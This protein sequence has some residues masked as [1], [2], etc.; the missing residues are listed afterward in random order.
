MKILYIITGLGIGGAEIV[1]ANLAS[2]MKKQGHSV[3]I[4]F[5]SGEQAVKVT[6]EITVINL[7]M[8]KSV[9]GFF[10]AMH[11]AK[12]FCNVFQPD[13]VHANLFHAI[14]FS[15]ILRLFTKISCLICTE[16]SNN[17]HGKVRLL[18]EHYTDFLSDM[19]TNVSKVATEYFIKSGVFSPKKSI[20]MYN[21]VDTS[22][23]C[24]K[25]NL[26]LRKSLGLVDNDFVFLN[27]SRF[28]E[29][30]DHETLINAFNIVHR[31]EKNTKLICVGDGELLPRIKKLVIELKL[32]E[33]V[34]FT[35]SKYNTEDYY[36]AS[37][38]F[39]LSSAYEGFGL[40]LVEAMA[41]GLE[42]I[43]T[44]CGGVREIIWNENNFVPVKQIDLL[45][46]K[47]LEVTKFSVEKRQF[48]GKTNRD[49]IKKFSL[50]TISEK[51]E[52]LYKKILGQK[53]SFL[54]SKM[55]DITSAIE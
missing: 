22:R 31:R 16:H 50:E 19:N 54:K 35:G 30:K 25:R 10:K 39:V 2:H 27:V 53:S 43:S 11:S 29:A 9:L 47:M 28:N 21:G 32:T 42:I 40:V 3:Q 8:K 20:T 37:D 55:T 41:C 38:C 5:L 4:M 13:I 14:L 44:D 23:F 34:I 49:S 26:L 6:Q 48:D 46:K 36:N 52:Y 24:I 33:H 18:L 51:W 45:A 7:R 17:Y 12:R 1:I 15:R